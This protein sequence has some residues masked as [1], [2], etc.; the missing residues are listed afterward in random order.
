[1]FFIMIVRLFKTL[2][3][4]LISCYIEK[5]SIQCSCIVF[6]WQ[7]QNSSF[8]MGVQLQAWIER[9]KSKVKVS[10]IGNM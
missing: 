8:L 1:M 5:D 3:L 9:T 7:V 4:I 2:N 6:A 10:W